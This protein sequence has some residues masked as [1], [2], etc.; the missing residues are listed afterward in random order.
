[1]LFFESTSGAEPICLGHPSESNQ[2]NNSRRNP[3][4]G[5]ED[6]EYSL[7]IEEYLTG[8]KIEEPTKRPVR[9]FN[10]V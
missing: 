9:S 7:S 3:R 2:T 1:M 4:P 8:Q 5:L 10:A 6:A